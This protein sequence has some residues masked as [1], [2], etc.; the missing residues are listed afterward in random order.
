VHPGD[1]HALDGTIAQLVPNKRLRR[2][3]VE[4][5]GFS[6]GS[7]STAELLFIKDDKPE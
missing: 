1:L 7:N 5:A 2:Q 3:Q 4:E 6:G